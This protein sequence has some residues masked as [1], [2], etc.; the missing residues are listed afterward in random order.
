MRINSNRSTAI[1]YWKKKNCTQVAAEI[2]ANIKNPENLMAWS[3]A[4]SRNYRVTADSVKLALR[5][6]RKKRLIKDGD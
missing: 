3:I 2:L 5:E 1:K 4:H 6:L